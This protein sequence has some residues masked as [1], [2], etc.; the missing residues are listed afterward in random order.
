MG[1]DGLGKGSV[2]TKSTWPQ[3]TNN[4]AKCLKEPKASP[5]YLPKEAT[6]Y[7]KIETNVISSQSQKGIHLRL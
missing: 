6:F 7:L 3:E 2:S 1:D 5:G 4:N